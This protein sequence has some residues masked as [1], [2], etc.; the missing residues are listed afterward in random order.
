MGNWFV[1]E[2]LEGNLTAEFLCL[3]VICCFPI[4]EWP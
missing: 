2:D 4:K 1:E 3:Y